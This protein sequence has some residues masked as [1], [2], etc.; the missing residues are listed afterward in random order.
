MSEGVRMTQ[1][2]GSW[3]CVTDLP[4]SRSSMPFKYTP[5]PRAVKKQRAAWHVGAPLAEAQEWQ[6][7]C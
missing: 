2:E 4:S 5:S 6:G 3:L 7:D 1:R